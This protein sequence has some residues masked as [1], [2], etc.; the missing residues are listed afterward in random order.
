[1]K[2]TVKL[3][4]G[5][6]MIKP[7]LKYPGAKWRIADWIVDKLPMHETY[8]EPYFGSGAIFFNKPPAKIETINDIDKDVINLFKVM[9]EHTEELVNLVNLTPYARDEYYM[10]YEKTSNSLEDARRFLVRCW[11]AYGTKTATRTGW[12]NNLSDNSSNNVKQWNSVSERIMKVIHRLKNVQIEN[13]DA[14][15]LI[16]KYNTKNCLI[17][18]DP[19]YITETRTRYIYANEIDLTHHE[20][21]LELLLNHSGSVVI[22]GY[23]HPL[24]NSYLKNWDKYTKLTMAEKGKKRMEVIWLK[25]DMK[26]L[27]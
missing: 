26:N 24:Y 7:I 6:K 13:A 15:E 11:Q 19:P 25:L 9:R 1:M 4:K 21:L 20:R 5:K 18:A 8:L 27:F 17:Y 10:S 22:S 12:R 3:Q 14:L 16:Q 2:F 23:E